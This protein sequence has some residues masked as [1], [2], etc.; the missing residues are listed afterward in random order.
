MLIRIGTFVLLL[1]SGCG[2]GLSIDSGEVSAENSLIELVQPAFADGRAN[3]L[4]ITL[5][6]LYLRPVAG[7]TPVIAMTGLRNT[8]TQTCEASDASGV[9]LCEGAVSS[10]VAETKTVSVLSPTP[11]SAP[12][13]FSLKDRGYNARA[14]GFDFNRNGVRG[15]PEDCRVCDGVTTDPDGDGVNEDLIY[16]DS[17]SGMDG[18]ATGAP[19]QPFQ[20]IAAAMAAA[21]GPGD[22]AEDILCLSGTF[23]EGITVSQSGV[24][25]QYTIDSF[26]Y[27]R[28][29]LGIFGWDKD[30]DGIYPPVDEDDV[31]VID[32]QQALARALTLAARSQI[33][34]GHLTFKRFRDPAATGGGF[35]QINGVTQ[36]VHLHD[37]EVSS[38]NDALADLSS[39]SRSALHLNTTSLTHFSLLNSS[40]A[41]SGG[42]FWNHFSSTYGSIIN[43]LLESNT[44]QMNTAGTT[45][46]LFV[47]RGV[48]RLSILRNEF[49]AELSNGWDLTSSSQYFNGVQTSGCTTRLTVEQ[50]DLIGFS[51]ALSV[52]HSSAGD[53]APPTTQDDLVFDSNRFETEFVRRDGVILSNALFDGSTDS[54]TN[55]I[56]DVRI[57]NNYFVKKGAGQ[58]D[59][60]IW[61]NAGNS[62][63]VNPGAV[64][65]AG[66]TCIGP[67]FYQAVG[68]QRYTGGPSLTF[69]M[70]RVRLFNN[71][72]RVL[73]TS[74]GNVF[75]D[76]V[77]SDWQANGNVYDTDTVGW[78]WNASYP[79][80]LASWQ[81]ASGSQDL[82]SEVCTPAFEDSNALDFHLSPSD[83]CAFHR[84]VDIS[85][86]T[87]RDFDGDTRAAT[88]VEAGA[89]ELL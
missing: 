11:F 74:G 48:D 76:F 39:G 12:V 54:A 52:N 38:M 31:A 15:E 1:L 35:V 72:F 42:R 82:L 89:D 7:V 60:C 4:R 81:T 53:C 9:A 86:Y 64:V 33:E 16:V 29:P 36:L 23:H 50:N 77:H 26:D 55:T 22:G 87:T 88:A 62:T 41:T 19:S 5:R 49:S 37:L 85:S 25:G 78:R 70:Q 8:V 18:T 30:R 20:T 13:V 69:P 58:A 32:G 45:G 34:V 51:T 43:L 66:N 73:N 71:I 57:T 3:T 63:G 21:D 68:V 56:E 47:L 2:L 67:Y 61:I 40:I 28:H 80:T 17:V 14:C 65:F 84:G 46:R 24:A 6:T 59:S 44:V 10:S 75:V 83:S 79:A 27:P